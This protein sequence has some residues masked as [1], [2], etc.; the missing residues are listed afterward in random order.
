MNP[1][2]HLYNNY[3]I[4]PDPAL[5]TRINNN[6]LYA[7]YEFRHLKL[8]KSDFR[9][10]AGQAWGA[11][12][13]SWKGYYIAKYQGNIQAQQI[14][15]AVTQR[16]A[17]MLEL[18]YIPDFPDIGVTANAFNETKNKVRILKCGPD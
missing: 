14:Y 9:I 3:H 13:K 17:D 5:A 18:P 10:M 1:Y 4:K 6:N 2:V 8:P 7:L 16:W 15:A 12:I 11:L